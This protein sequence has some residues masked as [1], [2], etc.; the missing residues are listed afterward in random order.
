MKK[1]S[2]RGAVQRIFTGQKKQ[3]SKIKSLSVFV[4]GESETGK[5]SI[6]N[7]LCDEEFSDAYSP[8]QF[9]IYEKM[10]ET[11][12][13]NN[14]AVKFIFFD[15]SGRNSCPT[16]RREYIN[17]ADIFLLVHSSDQASS[18]K[19]LLRYK[20]EIEE[21]KEDRISELSVAVIRN[22]IDIDKPGKKSEK[23]VS[24]CRSIYHCSAKYGHNMSHLVEFLTTESLCA[25]NVVQKKINKGLSGR[26]I[27]GENDQSKSI[28]LVRPKSYYRHNQ[29]DGHETENPEDY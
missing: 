1:I 19:Q 8:T 23:K 14:T 18:F 27:Y 9:D 7:V 29:E 3:K 15:I 12:G 21:V 28:R 22:K 25:D 4:L 10:M 11:D 26:Y 6:I 20:T 16:T 5:S 17:K 13:N 24:W 2:F